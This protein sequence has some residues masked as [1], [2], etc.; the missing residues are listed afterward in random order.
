MT[1]PG[2]LLRPASVP[3]GPTRT[4]EATAETPSALGGSFLPGLR[5]SS[6]SSQLHNMASMGMQGPGHA[7]AAQC[8]IATTQGQSG[9]ASG[10]LDRLPGQF[11]MGPGNVGTTHSQYG[12]GPGS[13]AFDR[14]QLGGSLFSGGFAGGELR[15]NAAAGNYHP[16]GNQ[17]E[18]F[19]YQQF[20]TTSQYSQAQS[21]HSSNAYPG[22]HASQSVLC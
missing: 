14:P 20:P 22:T 5:P 10:H 15:A 18:L 17:N 6:S 4:G 19:S 8:P 21:T 11:G 13:S 2:D 7:A 9:M 16:F 1:H 3:V 12:A